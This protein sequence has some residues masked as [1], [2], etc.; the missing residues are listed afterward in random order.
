[1]SLRNKN[2]Q[3]EKLPSTYPRDHPI[4]KEIHQKY[5][6]T[7]SSPNPAPMAIAMADK[8]EPSDNENHAGNICSEN[9]KFN[10]SKSIRK[11]RDGDLD[12]IYRNKPNYFITLSMKPCFD[13]N[14]SNYDREYQTIKLYKSGSVLI[15]KLLT[16]LNP[17]LKNIPYQYWPFF[18]GTIEHFDKEGNLVAPHLH[19]LVKHSAD[20]E[21]ITEIVKTL[22]AQAVPDA[23]ETGVDVQFIEPKDLMKRAR[24]ILKDAHQDGLEAL[25]NGVKPHE[26]CKKY[27]WS[28]D[29]IAHEKWRINRGTIHNARTT[30]HA[31]LKTND[32]IR[33]MNAAFKKVFSHL[34]EAELSEKRDHLRSIGRWPNES[35][36]TAIPVS[37]GIG[38]E[39]IE[40]RT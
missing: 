6:V 38:G 30:K 7:E 5:C 29:A 1:M 14:W 40:P 8:P 32:P 18:F 26:I 17:K 4:F 21:A 16:K 19:I 36:N 9:K 20:I 24:Y 37:P 33:K 3:K 39:F 31:L 34:S 11:S 35:I 2:G 15:Y 23:G 28:L 10:D 27:Q 25:E 12:L 13:K 22:W